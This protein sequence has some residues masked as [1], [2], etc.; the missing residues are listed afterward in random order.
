[1]GDL[2]VHRDDHS[3]ASEETRL[4]EV[5]AEYLEAKDL[6]RAGTPQEWMSRYPELA[7]ELRQFF[8]DVDHFQ[9]AAGLKRITPNAETEPDNLPPIPGEEDAISLSQ[10]A[11]TA[12]RRPVKPGTVLHGQFE[13][14][15]VLAGGMGQVFLARVIGYESNNTI[16]AIKTVPDFDV[17]RNS[18]ASMSPRQA[19]TVYGVLQIRFRR[20]VEMWVRLSRHMNIIWAPGVFDEGEKPYIMMEYADGGHLGD[21][22]SN[23]RIDV[24]LAVNLG[25]Q[26]C[27][28]MIH[29]VFEA[30]IVHRDIKPANV[31]LTRE[32][33]LKITDFGLARAFDI[34]DEEAGIGRDGSHDS[35]ISIAAA[36]TVAYMAPEQFRSI[37]HA[38][39]RSDIYS[40]GVM[41]YEMLTGSRLFHATTWAGHHEL[42]RQSTPQMRRHDAE[43]PSAL[44]DIVHRCLAF[45]PGDRYPSFDMLRGDL[46]AVY[47]ELPQRMSLPKEHRDGFGRKDRLIAES[48]A[49]I[50]LQEF[51]K[52]LKVADA[53]LAEFP[54]EAGF[55]VNKCKVLHELEDDQAAFDTY[56]QAVERFPTNAEV[57]A[58]LGWTYV[59]L[60]NAV[61]G[62]QA[63]EQATELSEDYHVAWMCRGHCESEL[64]RHGD[65]VESLRRCTRLAPYD[66]RGHHNLGN[67][68]YRTG[69][70]DE[71]VDVLHRAAEIAHQQPDVWILL[72]RAQ[73]KLGLADEACRSIDLAVAY[74]LD[75]SLA[76]T[77][78]GAIAWECRHDAAEA[79]RCLDKALTLDPSNESA[80][81]AL[82]IL[83]R[84]AGRTSTG[85]CPECGFSY[86]WNGSSC[87]HCGYCGGGSARI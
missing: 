34:A 13:V 9:G 41:L 19:R 38:D 33:I 55:W 52:A 68:L 39:T 48:S 66:W 7:E 87:D 10:R 1:M 71:A 65:A 80:H 22:I 16:I 17:W 14:T 69:R 18:H 60:G 23:G 86:K 62:L 84:S 50:A 21:W 54:D 74:G 45:E 64:G 40:F 30:G 35:E 82:L 24:P 6:G 56:M 27:D 31:L 57:W 77:V 4:D 73:G 79:R 37:S 83:R 81:A 76:W 3:S 28:G 59:S 5:I 29:A 26:F 61:A 53:G 44:S 67:V 43:I 46:M 25:L 42:R 32:G 12:V 85:S 63:A 11:Q 49:Y 58:N 20:E 36:G 72:A 15:D 78:R 2:M 47:H 75:D 51:D 70:L 8:I